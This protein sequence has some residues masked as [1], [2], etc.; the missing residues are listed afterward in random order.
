MINLI[1]EIDIMHY[2]LGPITRVFAE[3]SISRRGFD[4]EEGVA[5][6]LK[7]E[8]GVVGTFLLLDNVPSPHS[9]EAGTGENPMIPKAG[10]DVYRIIGSEGMVSVPDMKWSRYDAVKSWTETL[11]ETE[12]KVITDKAPFE[13]QIKHFVEV[14]AG[15][16]EPVCSGAAGLRAVVVCEAVKK[17]LTTGLPVDIEV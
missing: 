9:F 3:K 1:H 4:A 7:F 17:A 13:L 12:V 11:R 5:I 2:L 16:E 15:R 14:V 6:V 8:S 10:K